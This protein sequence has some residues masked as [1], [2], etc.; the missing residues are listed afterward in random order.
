MLVEKCKRVMMEERRGRGR[1]R[2]MA[3]EVASFAQNPVGSLGNFA[4]GAVNSV[5]GEDMRG[6][7]KVLLLLAVAGAVGGGIYYFTTKPAAAATP[8]ATPNVNTGGA[9]NVNALIGGSGVTANWTWAQAAA[10]AATAN[11]TTVAAWQA[12]GIPAATWANLGSLGQQ[13]LSMYGIKIV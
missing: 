7:A 8:A 10:L 9:Q 6:G 5:A 4:G 3:R 13:A 1:A 12:N 11:G 2:R